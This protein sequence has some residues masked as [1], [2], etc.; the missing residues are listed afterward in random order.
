MLDQKEQ[1]YITLFDRLLQIG[2]Q[3]IENF[4]NAVRKQALNCIRDRTGRR[5]LSE[6][7]FAMYV[8]LEEAA[9]KPRYRLT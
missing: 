2:D 6:D 9:E 3:H 4:G 1:A 8:E 5:C 7:D